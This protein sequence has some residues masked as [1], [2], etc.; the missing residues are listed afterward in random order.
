MPARYLGSP[1]RTRV[2]RKQGVPAPE[3][4]TPTAQ[5]FAGILLAEPLTLLN[6]Y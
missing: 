3:M 6:N 1:A 2:F 5:R 4:V